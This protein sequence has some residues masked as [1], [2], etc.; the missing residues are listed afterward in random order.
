MTSKQIKLI[1]TTLIIF[2]SLFLFYKW[3]LATSNYYLDKGNDIYNTENF[4]EALK[5][6]KYAEAISGNRNII[7]EIKI[8]RAEIFYDHWQLD[9]AEKELLEALDEK[10]N[11]YKAYELLGDVYLAKREFAKSKD[12][13]NQA[14][15]LNDNNKLNLKLIKCLI[16]NQELDSVRQSPLWRD[17]GEASNDD[18]EISYYLGLITLHENVFYNDYF[19]SVENNENYKNKIA[20]IKKVLEIY[21]DQKNSDY[22]A[23]L[24]ADLYNK[25]GEPYFAINKIDAIIKNNPSYCDAW[26]ISGKSNFIIGNYEKSLSDFE[27]ALDLDSNNSEIHFWI[28]SVKKSSLSL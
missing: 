6:Y 11:N 23:V 25:I 17:S 27:K 8:K 9:E 7:D 22:N 4:D 1:L 14:I 16:A 21:D 2:L 15:K 13:Y 5:N 19:R 28:A 18:E 10:Q 24:V 12:N 3:Q 20:E 26:I